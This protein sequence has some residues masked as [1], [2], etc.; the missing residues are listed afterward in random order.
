MVAELSKDGKPLQLRDVAAA[1]RKAD[2]PQGIPPALRAAEA[3]VAA[4]PDELSHYAGEHGVLQLKN[5]RGCWSGLS[6]V[7]LMHLVTIEGQ[8]LQIGSIVTAS[9]VCIPAAHPSRHHFLCTIYAD[10]HLGPDP[11]GH[12]PAASVR[13]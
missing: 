4:Q 9:G 12:A 3:L 13:L 8:M 10:A 2:D 1:L 11:Y 5:W 6:D 7:Q